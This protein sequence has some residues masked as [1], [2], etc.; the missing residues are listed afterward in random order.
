MATF[1]ISSAALSANIY[2]LD[3]TYSKIINDH[4]FTM[5]DVESK[6]WGA[7]ARVEIGIRSDNKLFYLEPTFFFNSCFQKICTAG[8]GIEDGVNVLPWMSIMHIH[9][10]YHSLDR[11]NGSGSETRYELFDSIGVRIRFVQ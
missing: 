6:D 7:A 1:A 9:R 11:L 10:S 4:D 8:L 3:L 5:P 2:R